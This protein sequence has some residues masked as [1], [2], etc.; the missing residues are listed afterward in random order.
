MLQ[1]RLRSAET[2]D[3]LDEFKIRLDGSLGG[4]IQWVSARDLELDN[5]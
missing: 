1:E 5:H 3:A 2:Q 4:L